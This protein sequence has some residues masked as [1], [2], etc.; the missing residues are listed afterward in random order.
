MIV[1]A[2]PDDALEPGVASR[3]G[4][5]GQKADVAEVHADGRYA[6][7]PACARGRAGWCRRRRAPG[8]AS[9]LPQF[10]LVD[11]L[12]AVR[13]GESVL[14][15]FVGGHDELEPEPPGFA[16]SSCEGA[17][18]GLGLANAVS[19][20]TRRRGSAMDGLDGLEGRRRP[21][22]RAAASEL[23]RV[24]EIRRST[25]RSPLVRDARSRRR[26]GLRAPCCSSH[27][28]MSAST[29]RWTAG[30]RT[31]PPLPT[32]S[33]PASNCGL[34]STRPAVAGAGDS[35]T[36]PRATV[37]EMN[38][39][40]AVTN[41]GANGRRS[42][43]RGARWCAPAPSRADRLAQAV[44]ELAVAHID[45]NH[46]RGAALQQPVDEAA[47]GAAQVENVFA[48][49][50]TL[51][52]AQGMVELVAAA[53]DVAGPLGDGERGVGVTAVRR[54]CRRRAPSTRT[55]PARIAA[56]A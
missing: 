13:V 30:S 4:D 27:A 24:A 43:L 31:T 54:A 41:D 19:T 40:S 2:A 5:T 1:V 3:S 25:P 6:R 42:A 20:A 44:V 49:D 34:T 35:S 26:R 29:S 23:T 56:R 7:C 10:V 9:T 28:P 45:G 46:A 16:A 37:R 17:V 39:T 33:R 47:G 12:V 38:D 18:G 15:G 11:D 22:R 50:G 36:G 52:N 48:R 8:R 55:S 53:R 32:C 14:G 21:G 51:E